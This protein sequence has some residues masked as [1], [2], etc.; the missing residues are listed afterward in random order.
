MPEVRIRVNSE[1]GKL[2]TV[3][4]QP[5]GKG[6]ERCTP[7]NIGIFAWD[8]VSSPGKEAEEHRKGSVP[9]I[10]PASRSTLTCF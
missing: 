7:I 1:I 2:R 6:I 5:P 10:Q 9:R 8:A 4:M 3:I